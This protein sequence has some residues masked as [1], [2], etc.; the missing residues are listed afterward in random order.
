MKRLITAS[1]I[2]IAAVLSAE[3]GM[4]LL[5]QLPELQLESKGLQITAEDIYSPDK[6]SIVNAIVWLGGCSASFVS[7]EGLLVTNHHCAFGALQRAST[8]DADY[9]ANGFLART[10]EEEME[11]RG[12]YAYVLQEMRDVTDEVL[13]AAKGGK[14]PVQ[15]DRRITAKIT[16]MTDRIEGERD[17]LYALIAT[18]F[19]GRQY[20]LFVYKKYQDVR[21]VYA[22]PA[23]IGNYGGDIDNWMWPRHTGDFTFLR[24]Y[25]GPD[26]SGAKYNPANVPLKPK[27][28]LRIASQPIREGD[29]TFILGFPGRTTRWRT[30]YSV[31]WNLE[32][33]YPSSIENYQ[34]LI[35]L[36]NDL[37]K[38]SPEGRIRVANMDKSFNNVMKNYQG[39]VEGM[40]RT[41]FL[42]KKRAFEAELTAFLAKDPKLQKQYGDVL[43]RIKALY[44]QLA[45]T[46]EKDDVL[47]LFSSQAGTLA[48]ITRQAYTTVREREKPKDKRD[49]DFSEKDVKETVDR[50]HLRYYNFWEP[51]DKAMLKR[52]LDKAR[53]LPAS[54]R[55]AVLDQLFP[56]EEAAQAFVDRAFA[57]TRL[58]DVE[59]AKSLFNKSAKELDALGDPL[60]D[61]MKALYPAFDDLKERNRVFNAQIKELRKS[62]LDALSIWKKGLIY[63]DA[64]STMRFTYGYVNGY[65]PADAVQYLPFTT[66]SGVIAK[67][68]GAEP[69]DAPEKLRQL[70]EQRDFGRWYDAQLKDVP[71]NFLHE[72]DITGGNSGSAVMNARGELIGLAFDGNYEALTSDWQY[73]PQLQRTISVDIRYVLFIV[74]KF[75]G[76]RWLLEEM[77]VR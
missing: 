23:A 60:I 49:P 35:Q 68:T 28:Y 36:M 70:Y 52:A 45:L 19:E 9:I 33:A 51:V 46:R 31:Q 39:N 76:A 8:K 57:E 71:V 21:L 58:K 7:P 5:T 43:P 75:A 41:R 22:P 37:T 64:N 73:D 67:H 53:N 59:F 65:R 32:Y 48:G 6:P 27:N 15:K 47:N 74:E 44:D 11:A 72:C 42:E 50:L 4:W 20:I 12:V 69:F 77:D 17:D 63:P 54:Q 24:V 25:Q 13:A 26:G 66:L 40:K 18:M 2:L 30:S 55:I 29:F 3:E 34:E 10:R 1:T 38:D 62:Y 16:E 61:L 56:N 14:D